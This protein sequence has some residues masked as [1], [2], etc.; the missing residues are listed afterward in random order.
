M[1]NEALGPRVLNML[2]GGNEQLLVPVKLTD[3]LDFSKELNCLGHSTHTFLCSQSSLTLLF[4]QEALK[5]ALHLLQVGNELGGVRAHLIHELE[6]L[7]IHVCNV[8]S[9]L[10]DCCWL[11][12]RTIIFY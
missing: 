3:R 11:H 1:L 7:P 8:L 2:A 6:D 9:R 5:L 12:F 4:H 10:N